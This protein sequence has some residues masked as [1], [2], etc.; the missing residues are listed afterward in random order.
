MLIG[1]EDNQVDQ[2]CDNCDKLNK[3]LEQFQ[4]Y[5]KAS[6][7][8][9]IILKQIFKYLDTDCD[10]IKIRLSKIILNVKI[11]YFCLFHTQKILFWF[12]FDKDESRRK[13]LD[14]YLSIALF[15]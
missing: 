8:R 14:Q 11:N 4:M 5:T 15:D 2:F 3:L 1:F 9:S 12:K 10:R 7:K 13:Q 6:S